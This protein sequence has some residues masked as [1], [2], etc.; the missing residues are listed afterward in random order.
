[1]QEPKSSGTNQPAADASPDQRGASET[2][3]SKSQPSAD[4]QL[5][6]I[7]EVVKSG[8]GGDFGGDVS[9]EQGGARHRQ[10]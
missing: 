7:D 2:Q 1:M 9:F 3:A 6:K 4:P 8:D 5:R 10:Q